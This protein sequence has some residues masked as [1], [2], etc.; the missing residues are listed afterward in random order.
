MI[1]SLSLFPGCRYVSSGGDPVLLPS[2]EQIK[3]IIESGENRRV[4]IG[5]SPLAL[6]DVAVDPNRLFGRHLASL[7][8]QVAANLVQLQVL[9]GGP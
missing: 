2:Q 8:T 6:N 5:T 7:E 9:F 3:S 4:K 1:P